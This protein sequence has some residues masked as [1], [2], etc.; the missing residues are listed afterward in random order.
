M[1][2]LNWHWISIELTAAPLLGL[3]VAAPFWRK[4]GMIFGNIVA[5]ALIFGWAFALIFREHIEIDR[6]VRQC[7]D[8]GIVCWP[9][10]GAFTRYAI[11]AF[12]AL[13]EVCG[14]FS[15]SLIVEKK[16]RDRDYAPEWR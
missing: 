6:I 15:I 14:L 11:Y 13:F 5:T 7:F 2:G 8:D 10:P 3:L 16:L 12:I 1:N 4:G 9:E